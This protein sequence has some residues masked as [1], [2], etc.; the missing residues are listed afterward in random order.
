MCG[1]KSFFKSFVLKNSTYEIYMCNKYI[2]FSKIVIQKCFPHQFMKKSQTHNIKAT[3]LQ[4]Y[5]AIN[6]HKETQTFW[7]LSCISHQGADDYL[8]IKIQAAS[9]Y[10]WITLRCLDGG[11]DASSPSVTTC[12]WTQKQNHS[13]EGKWTDSHILWPLTPWVC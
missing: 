8:Q 11:F 10:V 3:Y 5:I 12:F 6:T 9:A 4:S 2:C 1:K 13:S 7:K